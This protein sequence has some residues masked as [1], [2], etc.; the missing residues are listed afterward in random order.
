MRRFT[1][2]LTLGLGIVSGAA[3]AAPPKSGTYELAIAVAPM[4][5]QVPC[6]IKIEE[7]D[8]RLT[9]EVTATAPGASDL[10]VKDVTLDGDLL[11][12]T[13]TTPNGDWSFEGK[14][15]QAGA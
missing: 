9:G 2:L 14:V 8:G 13:L 6:L 10:S 12:F 5:D 4:A 15:P 11:R 7:K 1:L 3:P